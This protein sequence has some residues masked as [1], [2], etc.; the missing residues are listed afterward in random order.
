MGFFVL[1]IS[2][3]KVIDFVAAAADA[4][5]KRNVRVLDEPV[6]FFIVEL[7]ELIKRFDLLIINDPDAFV[8]GVFDAVF[9]HPATTAGIENTEGQDQAKS[10]TQAV[11]TKSSPE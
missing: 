8:H 11:I 4:F 1:A 9:R 3:S 2:K 10:E 5:G 7:V 6:E